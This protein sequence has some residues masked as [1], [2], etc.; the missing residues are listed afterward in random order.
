ML[1]PNK[2]LLPS[3]HS[4]DVQ[5]EPA[6]PPDTPLANR[7]PKPLSSPTLPP[8]PS[9]ST[10]CPT[11]SAS[12]M[13]AIRE[14]IQVMARIRPLSPEEQ[15]AEQGSSCWVLGPANGMISTQESGRRDMT[16][17]QFDAVISGTDNKAVYDIGIGDLVRSTMAGYNG[18]SSCK[19]LRRKH[20]DNTHSLQARCSHM[21][22]LQAEKHIRW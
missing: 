20:E 18:I 22:R 3:N 15:A 14:N 2:I 7:L 11:A 13:T 21:D 4:F 19:R 16:V 10:A 12:M 8:S 17:F 6:S 9:S 1:R 5:S